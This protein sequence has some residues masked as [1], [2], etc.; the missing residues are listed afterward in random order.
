MAQGWQFGKPLPADETHQ[1]LHSQGLL[2]RVAT[3]EPLEE[4][5]RAV[6]RAA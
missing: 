2:K 1:L 3:P 5:D 6:G 4:P